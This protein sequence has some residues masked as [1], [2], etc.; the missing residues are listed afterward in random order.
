MIRGLEEFERKKEGRWLLGVCKPSPKIIL[1]HW[2]QT[3]DG[4]ENESVFL[5]DWSICGEKAL[6]PSRM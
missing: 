5:D 4:I 2:A 6:G 1:G 3:L